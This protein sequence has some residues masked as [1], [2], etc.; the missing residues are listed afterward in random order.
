MISLGS[1]VKI[2]SKATNIAK[3]VNTPNIIVGIKFDKTRIENPKIIVML[4]KNIALP[5][6][7]WQIYTVSL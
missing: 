7:S 5:M 4:V 1:N 6:L 3:P 2:A